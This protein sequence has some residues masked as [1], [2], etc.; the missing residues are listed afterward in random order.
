MNSIEKNIY[1]THSC[2]ELTI[3]DVNKEVVLSGWINS[4]RKLG[5]ITFV[6]LRDNFGITQLLVKNED[7]LNGFSKECVVCVSG[8]VLERTSKNPNMLTGD[9]EVEVN[10]IKML[11]KCYSNLPFEI[12]DLT[13][14]EDIRLKYRYLNLR[15]ADIHKN[16]IKRSEILHYI[17]NK[18][19]DMGFTEVQTPILTSSSPEGARDYIVPTINAPGMFFAL[20]QAPQQY[21]QLL[22]VSGFDKYF[23]IAPCFRNE[24]ARA[25]R[26]P[27]E[28]YQIDFEMSFATQ[29]DVFKVAE[30]IA[31]G[32]YSNFTNFQICE[33]PFKRLTWKESREK[34]A[35][36]KPDLRNPLVV[37]TLNNVFKNTT[38]TPFINK[39]IK[40]IVAPCKEKSRKFFDE[41][42]K[43][44]L[45]KEGKGLCWLRFD[46]GVLSGSALKS[47]TET[48]IADLI[49]ELEPHNGDGIFIV[50]D[51]EPKAIKLIG[52][53]RNEL[54][55][56]LNLIDKNR[57]EFVWIID[58][59]FYERNEDTNQIEFAHNPFTMPQGGMEAL[60]NQKPEDIVAY[61]YDC[62]CNGYEML[63]GAVR[64]HE[65]EIMVKAFEIAGYSK[66][67]IEDK[68]SGLHNAFSFGA[69]PH[70]GGAFGFDR[71]LMPIMETDNIRDVITFPF[72]TNGNDLLMNSPSSI[73]EKTLKELGIQLFKKE[74]K[75][76]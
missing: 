17:R 35:S 68:F 40:A 60:L 58:F 56:S 15:N 59:P 31:T 64:N 34:Y 14:S 3:K 49:K 42:S 10:N 57:V 38:F 30:E 7:M 63:S 76:K 52:A 43:F 36:D 69:P 72:T 54:G 47:F 46:E 70:A 39:T 24:A 6:T 5:G 50:A 18:M 9:I 13:A 62:V 53:L 26:T 20:P 45:D 8:K 74:E 19:Y 32:M 28:F 73:D 51:E 67:D 16:V 21:K 2:G 65:P 71:M 25:D 75:S 37:K 23:Q 29:E 11:G 41:M 48:E 33:K 1:R 22:M 61:Q 55:N 12:N 66:K 4:I 27:G 44:I